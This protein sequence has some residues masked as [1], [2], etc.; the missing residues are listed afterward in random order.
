MDED[1]WWAESRN[2]GENSTVYIK[3]SNQYRTFQLT[4][5]TKSNI[6]SYTLFFIK[7]VEIKLLTDP[8][9][10]YSRHYGVQNIKK[11][12]SHLRVVFHNIHVKSP[13][14][15]KLFSIGRNYYIF[16]TKFICHSNFRYANVVIIFVIFKLRI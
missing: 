16:L 4:F 7:K 12:H 3:F 11:I 13:N 14:W 15:N 5:L 10:G 9:L 8:C 2:N 6:F 1:E